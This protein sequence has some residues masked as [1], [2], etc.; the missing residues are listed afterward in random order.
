MDVQLNGNPTG[1]LAGIR[2][3][4]LSSVVSGPLCA[5]ILGDL[6]AEVIKLE[7]LQGDTTRRFGPPFKAGLTPMFVQ[8]NRNKRSIAID[9]KTEAGQ[10]IARK[11]AAEVDVLLENFR[12]DVAER[13]GLGY[14]SLAAENPR[15]VYASICGFGSSGP[16]RDLPAYDSVIQGLVG[17]MHIQTEDE[18]PQLVKSIVADK[19]S[20]LTAAYS[21][22][23]ALFARERGDGRG[24]RVEI[25]MLDAYAAF[26]LPDVFGTQSFL[27]LEELGFDMAGVHRTW[28]TAD[29][30]VVMMIIEDHQF[31]GIL[32]AVERED[33]L[34]DPRCANVLQRLLH[35]QE[36]F[37]LLEGELRKW[38]TQEIV[39]RARKYDAP[40]APALNIEEFVADA[41]VAHNQT[42][43]TAEHP[44]AGQLQLLRSPA[45]FD[46]TPT[47]VRQLPP[48]IGEHTDEI[49]RDL[50]LASVDI[51]ALR[52]RGVIP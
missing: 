37:E 50:G 9:L 2:V 26:M 7:S 27:P 44:E 10:E 31:R 38:S 39:E 25:P 12:P 42:V 6:G 32:R 13:L 43:F 34:D 8:C 52:E 14:A 19:A 18:T 16:Y 15:L 11:L 29:G 5:Q 24:Q 30:H 51:A 46:R 22:M 4:D 41:Q 3:L 21:I 33:M 40:V 47:N 49:L 23:A 36:L 17:F 20:A 48:R 35:A 45:R 28:E 1:P